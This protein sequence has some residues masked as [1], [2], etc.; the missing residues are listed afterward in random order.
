MVDRRDVAR[1]GS[2][3]LPGHRATRMDG[4]GFPKG[5]AAIISLLLWLAV[6][7]CGRAIAYW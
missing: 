1:S 5:R 2:T 3:I 4:K 7:V 6:V